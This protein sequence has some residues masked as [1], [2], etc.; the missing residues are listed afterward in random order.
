MQKKVLQFVLCLLWVN[1]LF[2]TDIPFP[3]KNAVWNAI[4]TDSINYMTYTTKIYRSFGKIGYD[5]TL[6]AMIRTEGKKVFAKLPFQ[7][8]DAILYDF[9][10]KVGDVIQLPYYSKVSSEDYYFE[11]G[12]LQEYNY[13]VKGI[14]S[15]N[16]TDGKSRKVLVLT[17]PPYSAPGLNE[18]IW[19][20]GIGD[21][22]GIGL[23]NPFSYVE[24]M[25]TCGC[26]YKRMTFNCFSLNNQTVYID[27]ASVQK[28][29]CGKEIV[30]RSIG[31]AN[32]DEVAIV[33]TKKGEQA[34]TIET[35]TGAIA[36]FTVLD[37]L[38]HTVCSSK[39]NDAKASFELPAKQ[40]VYILTGQT[41]NG[42]RFTQKIL[43]K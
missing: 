20:E 28:C 15:I 32:A 36:Q 14:T 3:T 9:G 37:L 25:T 13:G 4:R 6:K 27:T 38:G 7:K 22:R 43:I 24:V 31:S 26:T 33:L 35:K 8:G 34:C 12:K 40:G 42:Q 1:T 23:L 41:T 5:Q 29:P 30:I 18:T 19:I 17:I 11:Y 2:A 10:L 16:T 39:N 21:I